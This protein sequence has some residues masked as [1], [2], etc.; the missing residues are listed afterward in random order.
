MYFR[1]ATIKRSCSMIW[2][3][4]KACALHVY[5][6]EIRNL[7]HDITS[8]DSNL[9]VGQRVVNHH[10]ANDWNTY[11]AMCFKSWVTYYYS[12]ISS[13]VK[14][15]VISYFDIILFR[16]VVTPCDFT[17]MH[18]LALSWLAALCDKCVCTNHPWA[19]KTSYIHLALN[20]Y[21]PSNI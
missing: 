11:H 13:R 1:R 20:M 8:N 2:N 16:N 17:T 9:E 7:P 21:L 18:C 3:R 5:S 4:G 15:W 12:D 19:G 14:W 10:N 6:S